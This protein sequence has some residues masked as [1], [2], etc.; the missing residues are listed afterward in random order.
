M[1]TTFNFV[2]L[3]K[4]ECQFNECVPLPE[5]IYF[6]KITHE[7]TGLNLKPSKAPTCHLHRGEIATLSVPLIGEGSRACAL[8]TASPPF[9]KAPFRLRPSSPTRADR[10][11]GGRGRHA[12][13]RELGI[14]E[15][16]ESCAGVRTAFTV[17]GV[18]CRSRASKRCCGCRFLIGCVWI[19]LRS[20]WSRVIWVCK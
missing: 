6:S 1:E 20:D 8:K 2:T 12:S 5:V 3:K 16:L 17:P 10:G 15:C 19:P 11:A 13:G 4:K 14:V 9:G 7:V 18:G